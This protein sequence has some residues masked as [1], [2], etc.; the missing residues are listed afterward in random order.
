[1]NK[2]NFS[3]KMKVKDNKNDSLDEKGKVKTYCLTKK[4]SLVGSMGTPG[5]NYESCSDE[6]TWLEN[7]VNDFE[8]YRMKKND[9]FINQSVDQDNSDKG[10]KPPLKHSI[11]AI[12]IVSETKKKPN[13]TH[14]SIIP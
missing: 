6:L 11:R 2:I 4:K 1:M 14:G 5:F 9:L 12:R 3:D 10:S 13:K 7:I 8:W